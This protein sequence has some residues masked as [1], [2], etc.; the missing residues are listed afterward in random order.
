MAIATSVARRV[1]KK[2]TVNVVNGGD[3]LCQTAARKC[4]DLVKRKGAMKPRFIFLL[5]CRFML[6]WRGLLRLVS[7]GFGFGFGPEPIAV[8]P[9]C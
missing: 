4:T 2:I 7:S 9:S 6:W 3:K 5:P 8:M 1:S